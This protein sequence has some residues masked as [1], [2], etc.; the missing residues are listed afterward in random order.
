MH[1]AIILGQTGV[2]KTY[3]ACALGM[4]ANRNFYSVRY[5]HLPNLLVEISVARASGTYRDYMKK[6]K[7]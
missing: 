1:N 3:L 4:A 6:L 5:I 2:G 7:K